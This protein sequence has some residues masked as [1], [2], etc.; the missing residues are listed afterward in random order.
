MR[1]P[2]LVP[3]TLAAALA[4]AAAVAVPASA[5]PL[6]RAHHAPA[7]HHAPAHPAA[8]APH[9]PAH[10]APAT[11][12]AALVRTGLTT[13]APYVPQGSATTDEKAPAGFRPVFT[14]TVSRHGSRGLSDSDD[15]DALLALWTEAKAEGALTATGRTLGPDVQK[16]LDANAA[17]GYGLLTP[18]G[19]QELRSTAE[20]TA[21]RLPSL[22][23]DAATRGAQGT[24][25][26]DVVAASQ[27]RT[28]DSADQYVA[29]LESVVPGLARGVAPV[30]TDDALLYFHKSDAAYLDYVKNDPRVGAAEAQAAALPKTQAVARA[31]LERSF[32]PAFVASV[33]AGKHADQF[34]DALAA[35][36]AVYA[37]YQ[38]TF[39]FPRSA[40]LS[41]DRYVT[42]EQASWLGY[43][44]D[45]TSFY[46]NG[47]GFTGTDATYAMANGLLDDLFAQLDAK[48]AGTSTLDAALRFT[49]A[50]E[51]FPLAT[52]LGLP[53]S[54]KQLPTGTLFSYANDPFRGADVAPMAANVQWDLYRDGHTYLVQM[55]Y[56]EKPTAFK[57]SCRP[58]HR[59]STFY[60]LDELESCYG[61]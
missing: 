23:R 47:P 48:R 30:R 45:V 2:L 29:G 7:T 9:A 38:V 1:R 37:L 19:D 61:R 41:F 44:D 51:I 54:T 33:A 42:A 13:K 26:V 3:S 6:D 31:V 16:I 56:D 8:P 34:P 27:A 59:G 32:T 55:R 39:D 28:V 35:A 21:Q 14:E 12:S 46:E 17:N 10:P 50:E 36:D 57:A 18:L 60:D 49:H 5:H 58:V 24:T 4:L 22:F 52:L 20:R 15:G 25:T 11:P 53:G 40:G 43:L